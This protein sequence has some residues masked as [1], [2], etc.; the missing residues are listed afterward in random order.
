M[1]NSIEYYS[2]QQLHLLHPKQEKI[3]TGI[4]DLGSTEPYINHSLEWEIMD[5]HIY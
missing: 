3:V 4:K 2:T 5:M 1:C